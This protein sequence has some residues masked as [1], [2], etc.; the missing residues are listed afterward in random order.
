MEILTLIRA[1]W[2]RLLAVTLVIAGLITLLVGWLGVSDAEAVV[3]QLP[4]ITSAGVTGI[5]LVAMGSVMWVSADL[6]DQ[7]RELRTVRVTL[8]E[9]AAS[10][11]PMTSLPALDDDALAPAAHRRS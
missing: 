5:V 1:Q 10:D 2:D 3:K 6:R 8:Q 9:L 4:Y 7:W 11:R